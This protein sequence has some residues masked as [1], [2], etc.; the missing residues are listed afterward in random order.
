MMYVLVAI[1]G[2]SRLIRQVNSTFSREVSKFVYIQITE[3]GD[4]GF[5]TPTG[6]LT[7]RFGLGFIV[8]VPNTIAT[9][10]RDITIS[11]HIRNT[12]C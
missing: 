8:Y 3:S 5:D 9:R 12:W 11:R 6:S 4:G 2:G 1:N 10:S 7:I